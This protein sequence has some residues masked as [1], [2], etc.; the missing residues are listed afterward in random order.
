MFNFGIYHVEL[1]RYFST[2]AGETRSFWRVF[3]EAPGL[4]SGVMIAPAVKV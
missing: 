4:G 3:H 1:C 2:R